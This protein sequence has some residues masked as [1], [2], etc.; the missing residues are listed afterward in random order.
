MT[1]PFD[2]IVYSA[3]VVPRVPE[4]P[5]IDHDSVILYDELLSGRRTAGKRVAVIGAGGI[6]V[7]VAEYLTREPNQTLEEWRKAW[8]VVDPA[9]APGGVGTPVPEKPLREVHLL[10]RKETP[11]GKGLGKTSGWVHRAEL[12]KAGVHKYVGVAYDRIDD[13]GLHITI[14]GQQKVIEVDNIIVCT[15]QESDRSSLGAGAEDPRIHVIGGADV[16]AEL[17]AKRAIRQAVELAAELSR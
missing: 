7:D 9:E 14:D 17:D 8:G 12:K 1:K 11:I 13:A 2:H 3:G 6:G 10:Q 16:A 4:I 5:G 15:G